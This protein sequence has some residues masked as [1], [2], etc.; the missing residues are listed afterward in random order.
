MTELLDV[1]QGRVLDMLTD[2]KYDEEWQDEMVEIA[3][4]GDR[5]SVAALIAH[6]MK[7]LENE[8]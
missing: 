3:G 6:Y 2:L 4:E 7:V 5:K 1:V 8:F